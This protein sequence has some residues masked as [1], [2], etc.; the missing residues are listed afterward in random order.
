[1]RI[2]ISSY[3]GGPGHLMR[4]RGAKPNPALKKSMKRSG[5]GFER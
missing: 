3:N 5:R 1:M 4:Y 2:F